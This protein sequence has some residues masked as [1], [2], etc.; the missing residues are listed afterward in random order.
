MAQAAT[1]SQEFTWSR[2][3]RDLGEIVASVVAQEEGG[4]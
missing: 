1:R 4:L 2:F 3:R